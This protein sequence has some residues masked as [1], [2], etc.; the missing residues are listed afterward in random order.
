[1]SGLKIHLNLFTRKYITHQQQPR[2]FYSSSLYY[3]YYFVFGCNCN[4]T[5]FLRACNI[6][7]L[8]SLS[9]F[10]FSKD[11]KYCSWSSII[12]MSKLIVHVKFIDHNLF[13]LKRRID[14]IVFLFVQI[15]FP[16]LLSFQSLLKYSKQK[17]YTI[18]SISWC[19]ALN[20]S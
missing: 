5:F 6:T 14:Q 17:L 8:F 10:F 11:Y 9:L 2:Y 4:I 18:R 19:F 3:F 20:N 13:L 15:H 16:K 7:F 1:M 12:F